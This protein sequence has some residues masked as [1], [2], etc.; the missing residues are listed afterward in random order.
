MAHARFPS[1][2][3][4]AFKGLEGPFTFVGGRTLYYDPKEGQYWDP[5]TDYFMSNED[6]NYIHNYLIITL[7][8]NV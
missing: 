6:M 3:L 8:G 4:G 5:K 1:S 2:G 7:Q